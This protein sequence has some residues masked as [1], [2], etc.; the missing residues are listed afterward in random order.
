[1]RR[2]CSLPVITTSIFPSAAVDE[3]SFLSTRFWICFIC[4][5]RPRA[6]FS[7]CIMDGSSAM[8]VSLFFGYRNLGHAA[9]EIGDRLVDERVGHRARLLARSPVV[10]NALQAHAF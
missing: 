5:C 10:L 2:T 3:I 7:I 6:C 1:M 4:F 8:A 9:A